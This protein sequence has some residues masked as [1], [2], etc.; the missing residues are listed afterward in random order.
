MQR[1]IYLLVVL[2]WAIYVTRE[3]RLFNSRR[4]IASPPDSVQRIGVNLWSCPYALTAMIGAW[5][6]WNVGHRGIYLYDQSSVFDGGWR[7]LQGQGLYRA[8]FAPHGPIVFL[9]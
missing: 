3:N 2:A 6:V 1:T 7:I 4:R 9:L 8:V 5:V